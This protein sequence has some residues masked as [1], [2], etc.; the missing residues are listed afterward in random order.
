MATKRD[1]Y[2]V[3][4]VS[5]NAGEDEIRRRFRSLAR[6][7]HP[8]VCQDDGA[9]ERFKEINEAYQ[10]LCDPEK[11]R[12]YDRYGHRGVGDFQD[13]G[14]FTGFNFEDIFESFFG[15]GGTAGG[16]QRSQRGSD[17]HCSISLSFEEAVF[18]CEKE[19]NLQRLEVCSHC[20]GEGSEPGTRPERCSH[21]NGT[22]EIRN[23]QQSIFGRFVSVTVCG[24]CHGE[25]Q[26]AS[27]P[28]KVCGGEGMER[29]TRQVKIRVP[30]GVEDSMQMPLA[31]QGDAG[32]RGGPPGTLYVSFMVRPHEHFQRQGNDLLFTQTINIAQAALGDEVEIPTLDGEPAKLHIPAGTQSGRIFRMKGRGVPYL[33]S[34]SRGDLQVIVKVN[35]PTNLSDE[36]K[37][38]LR[39]LASTFEGKEHPSDDGK[40][41]L[42]KVFGR[43]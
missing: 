30:A 31:G 17:L 40:G 10:V 21:C 39:R 9:E 43:D 1:Y 19:F 36:Q 37:E 25:G 28:C 18:G 38:L 23:L 16:R 8:D 33:R 13:V 6:Q 29:V 20:N 35:T 26:V 34:N 24:R 22:G 15:M 4:G 2:E 11:R 41:I 7:Y 14:G 12:S 5:R 3:L 42:H 32:L 27:T